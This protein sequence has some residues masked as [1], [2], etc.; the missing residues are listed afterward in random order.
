MH[1]WSQIS[2]CPLQSSSSEKQ[3]ANFTLERFFLS[4]KAKCRLYP[5]PFL[6]HVHLLIIHS[7]KSNREIVQRQGNVILTSRLDENYGKWVP[8]Y[9]YSLFLFSLTHF[10]ASTFTTTTVSE[11]IDF[12]MSVLNRIKCSH[13]TYSK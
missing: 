6:S 7:F 5:P 3:S 11:Q 9:P 2:P 10:P 4:L 12:H 13:S 8:F 1:G